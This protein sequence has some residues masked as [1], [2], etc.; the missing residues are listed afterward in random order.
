MALKD[1]VESWR[2]YFA[3]RPAAIDPR[4]VLRKRYLPMYRGMGIKTPSQ[5]AKQLVA[6]R[7][8]AMN[9][10]TIGH[11]NERVMEEVCG[12]R[13]LTDEEKEAWAGI[14][15]RKEHGNRVYLINLKAST[16]TPNSA[17]GRDTRSTLLA[18]IQAEEAYQRDHPR[19]RDDNPLRASKG[20][21]IGVAGFARGKA[22][23]HTEDIGDSEL[24]K[25]VGDDLWEEL[26]AGPHFTA[27]LIDEM[28]RHPIDRGIWLEDIAQAEAK[29]E[30]VI[31]RSGCV[32]TN[33]E[34]DWE[35]LNRAFPD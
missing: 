8:V 30:S 11:L 32:D 28:G 15:F 35:C 23:R 10:M 19:G 9:E 24:H 27:H 17:I 29:M 31:A 33:G 16:R 7:L 22:S 12:A 14:D 34:I 4:D 26:G 18:A 3:S 21:I 25:L 5:L 1:A 6:D 2:D 13:K 20:G